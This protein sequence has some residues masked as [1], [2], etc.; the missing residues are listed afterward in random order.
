MATDPDRLP[1]EA[2]LPE[3]LRAYRDAQRIISARIREALLDPSARGIARRR[4]FAS[5]LDAVLRTLDRLGVETDPLAR[6]LVALA[7]GESATVTGRRIEALDIELPTERSFTGV[8]QQAVAE[9]QRAALGRLEDARRTVGRRVEDVFARAGRRAALQATLGADGSR[10]A[11]SGRLVTDLRQ[12]GIQAFTDR[13]GRQWTLKNYA[14][15]VLRTTT[16]EAVVEGAK[17]RMAASGIN[18][19]RISRHADAC[20]VCL[21]W[22]GRLVALDGSAR[23]L[24]GEPVATLDAMPN[25][26]PPFHPRCRHSLQPVASRIDQVARDL[27]AGRIAA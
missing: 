2:R 23:N 16:R 1:Y 27:A 12:R 20:P 17:L 19:A 24:E 7:L 11:A 25:G 3:L 8:S 4:H 26:G 5:Q 22:E 14:E 6:D 10:R 15:M 13:A 18:V 9:L 21:P